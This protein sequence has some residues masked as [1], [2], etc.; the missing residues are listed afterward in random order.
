MF[1]AADYPFLDLLWT[2]LIFFLWIAWFW[3]L[4]TV[5]GDIFR[6]H[7]ISGWTKTAWII[8]VIALPF[9]GVFVYLISQDEGMKRRNIERMEAQRAQF[10][11]Y[12]RQ[13]AGAGGGASEIE[14]A[15]ALLDSGAIDQAEFE[16]LKAKA[17]GT[18]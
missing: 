8:F 7:D 5:L 18:A 10:D 6:R 11:D 14:K 3:I 4:F 15:K 9:L 12:V 1:L 17:L 13:A 16:A 2:M